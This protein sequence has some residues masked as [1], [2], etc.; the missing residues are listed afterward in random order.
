L[1]GG[2]RTLT[3]AVAAAAASALEVTRLTSEL[4]EQ[5]RSGA[6]KAVTLAASSLTFRAPVY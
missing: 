5:K 1:E 4:A 2:E 6:M 3:A